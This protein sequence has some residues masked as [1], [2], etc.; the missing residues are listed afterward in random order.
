MDSF[1]IIFLSSVLVGSAVLD[2]RLR[3]IP[4]LIT[5]PTMAVAIIY[6]SLI[7]GLD[8]LVFSTAGLA[9]GI[10]LFVIPYIK[11]GMGAGD[12]KLMGAVG[13]VLGAR[14]VLLASLFTI[15]VGGV[16]ALIL[17]LT[18]LQY[19]K[20]F[21]TR[22][23]TTLKTLIFTR[24]FIPITTTEKNK[25]PKLCFGLAIALGTSLY[26]YLELSGHNFII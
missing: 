7:N 12:T 16:Y 15:L 8:G 9:L 26:I 17:L 4:N 25:E 23:A 19:S 24:Q 14:G 1:L 20:S 13:A 18:N 22:H 2:L 3:K 11:G 21:I 6:H 10:A 5:Y